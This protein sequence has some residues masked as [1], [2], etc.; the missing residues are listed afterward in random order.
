[1]YGTTKLVGEFLA[2]KAAD[3]GLN[4]LC[5]R[6]FSGYGEGQSLDYPVPAICARA[7]RREDPLVVWG[8]GHQMRD[9]VHVDDVVRATVCRL[10]AGVHRYQSMN[11][12]SGIPISFRDIARKAAGIVGY[13]PIITIDVS[14]PAGVNARYGNP[15]RMLDYYTPTVGLHEGLSRVIRS[16]P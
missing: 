13:N 1:M 3:Y 8:S 12:S 2:W 16:L 15:A 6:P 4:T 10:D 9:F 7:K 5:I 14:K 11:I